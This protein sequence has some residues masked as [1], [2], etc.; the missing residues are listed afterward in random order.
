MSS[1]SSVATVTI[2]VLPAPQIKAV[3]ALES[4]APAQEC[5]AQDVM[6]HCASA[7]IDVLKAQPGVQDVTL[8]SIECDWIVS[9]GTAPC[10]LPRVR[11]ARCCCRRLAPYN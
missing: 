11:Q 5:P 9:G 1:A 6:Q 8:V 4:D 7:Y 10:L 2:K 3:F